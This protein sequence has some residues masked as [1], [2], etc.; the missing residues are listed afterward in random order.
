MKQEFTANIKQ[1]PGINGAYVE[2]PFDVEKVYGS[3]RL[4]VKAFFDG[5]EYR[6]SVVS[7]GGEYVLGITQ[8]IRSRIGKQFGDNVLVTLEKDTDER[9]VEIPEDLADAMKGNDRAES[10][11]RSLSYTAQKEYAVWITS[12]KREAT[13]TDRVKKAVELLSEGKKLK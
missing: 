6:G 5:V 4:K 11:F 10:V 2:I 3:K 8:E 1:H 9:R 12:A 7:M 13:R